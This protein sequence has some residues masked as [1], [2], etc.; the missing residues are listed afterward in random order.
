[1]VFGQGSD[2]SLSSS[3]E[4]DLEDRAR[5]KGRKSKFE[6]GVGALEDPKRVTKKVFGQKKKDKGDKSS[7]GGGDEKTNAHPARS[8]GEV[9]N[10]KSGA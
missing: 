7:S 1:M 10:E 8:D 6:R 4:D 5:G 2:G 3:D 9:M